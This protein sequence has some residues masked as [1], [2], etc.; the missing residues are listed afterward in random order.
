M[1]KNLSKM[2]I[3]TKVMKVTLLPIKSTMRK[4]KSILLNAIR[5][6]IISLI[7]KTSASWH[8][9]QIRSTM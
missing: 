3:L 1:K 9:L 4:R 6:Q 8:W 5:Q 7:Y 2:L